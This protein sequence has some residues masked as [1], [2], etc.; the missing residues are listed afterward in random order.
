MDTR[1]AITFTTLTPEEV[2]VEISA[3]VDAM[4][5]WRNSG[6]GTLAQQAELEQEVLWETLR[7]ARAGVRKEPTFEKWGRLWTRRVLNGENGDTG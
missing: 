1:S 2:L 3:S 4:K 6:L 5:R 7:A